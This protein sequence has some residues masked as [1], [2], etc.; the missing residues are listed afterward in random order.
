MQRGAV[1][2][3]TIRATSRARA[4]I[5]PIERPSTS[6]RPRSASAPRITE[7]P[8][9]SGRG[10]QRRRHEQRR[11]RRPRRRRSSSRPAQRRATVGQVEDP[12][13]G[14]EEEQRADGDAQGWRARGARR[15]SSTESPSASG[16]TGGGA[17][18]PEQ[19][20][21]EGEAGDRYRHPGPAEHRAGA[22]GERRTDGPARAV[23]SPRAKMTP[24]TIERDGGGVGP[25]TGELAARR[26]PAP[27]ERAGRPG[28]PTAGGSVVF[29]GVRF[30]VVA[31]LRVVLRAGA[32]RRRRVLV[33]D[34]PER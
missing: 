17:V 15:P 4:T 32:R 25:V 14:D 5:A 12:D 2:P 33:A 20:D 31:R 1:Q 11:G 29:R 34:I 24:A 28:R 30:R 13:V 6:S 16:S 22:V 23:Q 9:D 8:D 26:L 27:G 3:A 19:H 18:G 10:H 7:A 21:R